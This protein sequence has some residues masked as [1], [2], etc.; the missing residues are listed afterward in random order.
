MYL[1]DINNK[2]LPPKWRKKTFS[3]EICEKLK[4]VFEEERK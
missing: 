4:L 3:G 1:G 2:F